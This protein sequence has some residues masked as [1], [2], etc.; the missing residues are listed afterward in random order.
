MEPS[1]PPEQAHVVLAKVSEVS[2]EVRLIDFLSKKFTR[3]RDVISKLNQIRSGKY[4]RKKLLLYGYMDVFDDGLGT[5]PPTAV[6]KGEGT[7]L[8]S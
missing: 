5:V 8:L 2:E 4:S 3:R 7:A 6:L 1:D